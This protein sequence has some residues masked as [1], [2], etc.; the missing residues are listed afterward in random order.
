MSL[1]PEYSSSLII[2]S[3]ANAPAVSALKVA[4][5]CWFWE[6]ADA[7]SS[8]LEACP[9]DESC[10][11]PEVAS[12]PVLA[13]WFLSCSWAALL[14]S[15][16]EPGAGAHPENDSKSKK[17]SMVAAATDIKINLF[18]YADFAEKL[19]NIIFNLLALTD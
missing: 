18:L 15:E 3:A 11:E 8:S 7:E 2:P 10:T 1:Y 4:G 13:A 5:S 16:A 12:E 9:D 19:K 17:A 6:D 14:L